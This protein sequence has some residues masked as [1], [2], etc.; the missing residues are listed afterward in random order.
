MGKSFLVFSPLV[1]KT[2]DDMKLQHSKYESYTSKLKDSSF[3]E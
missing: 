3:V 2:M 1:S